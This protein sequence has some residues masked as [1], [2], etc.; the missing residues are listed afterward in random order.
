MSALLLAL[1]LAPPP[2]SLARAMD[3][4]YGAIREMHLGVVHGLIDHVRERA[5]WL[6]AHLVVPDAPAIA[7]Q[8]AAVRAEAANLAET[9]DLD[10]AAAGVA[11][12]S[13]ACGACHL[14]AGATTTFPYEPL[15]RAT[16]TLA[17]RMLRHRWAAARMWEGLVGPSETLWR[18]GARTLASAPLIDDP[19][20]AAVPERDRL[21]A[22]AR[23]VRR[24]ARRATTAP[25]E[26]RV[27]LYGELLETCAG[28][29][30][31]AWPIVR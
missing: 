19:R 10:E 4:H 27:E 12:L 11:R 18:E 14:A 15:P 24:L 31:L 25:A 17:D 29:H 8:V 30:R 28:C 2:T 16:R 22:L 21:R 7:A 3:E 1:L 26:S 5:R 20:L 23:G 9:P 6:G 13:G